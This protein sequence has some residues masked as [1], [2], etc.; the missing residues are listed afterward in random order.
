MEMELP[1]VVKE[2][3]TGPSSTPASES[4]SKRFRTAAER[5]AE[6]QSDP[7]IDQTKITTK[8]VRCLGCGNDI[9][10]DKREGYDYYVTPWNK[11]KKACKYVKEGRMTDKLRSGP[12]L[13]AEKT[14][15]GLLHPLVVLGSTETT[16]TSTPLD[17]NI[18]NHPVPEGF[19]MIT[20]GALM[21]GMGNQG[22][23]LWGIPPSD[24]PKNL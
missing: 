8:K 7:W 2:T 6:L 5:K 20:S 17:L 14:R 21:R 4:T 24:Q 13:V 18:Q 19:A 12:E 1:V 9:K 11:H 15:D 22:L 16:R 10:L 3:F 23:F